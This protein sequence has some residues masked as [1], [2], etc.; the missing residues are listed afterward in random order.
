LHNKYPKYKYIEDIFNNTVCP[1]L[2]TSHSVRLSAHR[3]STQHPS[4]CGIAKKK[5]TDQTK[6][7]TGAPSRKTVYCVTQNYTGRICL[8][9]QKFHKHFTVTE[10]EELKIK[11]SHQVVNIYID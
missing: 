5:L 8:N 11:S 7:K 6:S 1:T 3:L 9:Y 2:S 10:N 4:G